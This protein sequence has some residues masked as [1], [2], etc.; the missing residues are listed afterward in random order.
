MVH[1]KIGRDSEKRPNVT[2][3]V[4]MFEGLRFVFILVVVTFYL[5]CVI[6]CSVFNNFW[7]VGSSAK[8]LVIIYHKEMK[9]LEKKNA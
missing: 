6:Y 5:A 7:D 9:K 1:K 8:E 4:Y 3:C 2:K